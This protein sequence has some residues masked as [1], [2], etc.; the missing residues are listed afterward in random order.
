MASK[1]KI[2]PVAKI[3][4]IPKYP[5]GGIVDQ[6]IYNAP[7]QG[8]L[9]MLGGAIGTGATVG[10]TALGVP[11]QIS[12]LIGGV[13]GGGAAKLLK[14]P[15]ER[16]YDRE[17]KERTDA[18]DYANRMYSYV[19]PMQYAAHGLKH[20][21]SKLIEVEKGEV[22]LDPS[23][24][25]VGVGTVP[26]SKGGNKIAV[27]N[28]TSV[29]PTQE[30]PKLRKKLTA[31]SK[32]LEEANKR[33]D[34]IAAKSYNRMIE[35]YKSK[36]PNNPN[37]KKEGGDGGDIPEDMIPLK[38]SPFT[39][40]GWE[41]STP[42]LRGLPEITVDPAIKDKVGGKFQSVNPYGSLPIPV[43][44]LLDGKGSS[45]DPKVRTGGI[46]LEGLKGQM[47][48]GLL[49]MGAPLMYNAFQAMQ[50]VQKEKP[51]YQRPMM[52]DTKIDTAAQNMDLTKAQNSAIKSAS[53]MATNAQQMSAIQGNAAAN[54]AMGMAGIR[55][56]A[57]NMSRQ[58]ANQNTASMNQAQAANAQENRLVDDLISQ[59]KGARQRFGAE[60]AFNTKQLTQDRVA[61]N[62]NQDK[63]NN[64][65]AMDALA[66]QTYQASAEFPYYQSDDGS[67][68]Q[69]Y[70]D[71]DNVLRDFNTGE[72]IDESLTQVDMNTITANYKKKKKKNGN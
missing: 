34:K 22:V 17:F 44:N 27:K 43:Q 51:Y 5:T 21:K 9:D 1:R 70:R 32:R 62:E 52:I 49:G 42:S 66:F 54:K 41:T 53:N 65:A 45:P 67:I 16:K 8:G 18:A 12:Q 39:N 28:G 26:H 24:K 71:E 57:G 58:L 38:A 37:F 35:R 36:L 63:M 68:K 15:G 25:L 30:D 50:K 33:G 72:P 59:N 48:D 40:A 14:R 7:A 56:Q 69:A 61:Y 11:P 2:T 29:F 6:P 47:N 13:A 64:K 23:N 55:E 10:L 3:N 46:N 19:D 20:S 31:A 60:A 4:K